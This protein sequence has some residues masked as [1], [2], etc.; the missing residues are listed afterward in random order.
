MLYAAWYDLPTIALWIFYFNV[1]LQLMRR[2]L[3]ILI[4]S[5]LLWLVVACQQFAGIPEPTSTPG[6]SVPVRISF[7]SR[8]TIFPEHW[9][10]SPI[11]AKVKRLDSDEEERS[12]KCINKAMGKYPEKVLKENLTTVYVLRTLNF[13]DVGFGATYYAKNLYIANSGISNGYTDKFI[14]QSFHHEF[15]SI[16]FFA[17]ASLFDKD[18]WMSCNPDGFEYKDEATGGVQSLKDDMDGT[19]FSSV[20]NKQGF[21]DQYS[22]SSM[23]NDVNQLAQ[24]LFCPDDGFWA[25][26]DRHPRLQ[27]KVQKLI[28]FYNAIDPTF[29]LEFFRTLNPGL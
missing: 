9:R 2:W 29:T 3:P 6:D 25:V 5:P 22:Q 13:Y 4:L 1:I 21:I 11:N 18:S 26:V 14:E 17:Y 24:Q 19:Y 23:E 7:D 12:T 10:Q 20:Y 27:C 28:A 16:L 8:S 15:S